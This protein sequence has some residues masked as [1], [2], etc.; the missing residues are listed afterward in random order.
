MTSASRKRQR[1]AKQQPVLPSTEVQPLTTE[2][3]SST[4]SQASHSS[5][6]PPIAFDGVGHSLHHRRQSLLYRLSPLYVPSSL[7][8]LSSQHSSL[9]DLLDRTL[10]SKSNNAALL[11]GYSGAGKSALM[12]SVLLDL[13]RRHSPHGRSFTSVRLNGRLHSDDTTG[14]R[15]LVRQL[16]VDLEMEAPPANA[17]FTG[18]YVYLQDILRSSVLASTPVFFLLDHFEAFAVDKSKQSLLYNLCDLLQG[19]YQLAI[20]GLSQRIDCYDLLEKRIKSRLAAHRLHF[21]PCREEGELVE[22]LSARLTLSREDIIKALEKRSRHDVDFIPGE[23]VE[24]IE[25]VEG[26]SAAVQLHNQAV[27]AV[28]R[29]KAVLELLRHHL[30]LGKSVRWFLTWVVSARQRQSLGAQPID[31][32]PFTTSSHL[33]HCLFCCGVLLMLC[34]LRAVDGCG[35]SNDLR[36]AVSYCGPLHVS[37]RYASPHCRDCSPSYPL[38]LSCGCCAVLCAVN[39]ERRSARQQ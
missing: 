9:F 27:N 11:I 35:V 32:R 10:T 19:D 4:V 1:E 12:Q 17:D 26:V 7:P 29:D 23:I 33:R 34:C 8:T 37:A 36:E 3:S 39:A 21:T 15:E 2:Q 25:E 38:T 24:G 31:D 13:H 6:P 14:M 16:T 28:F 5:P 30:N 18:L 22:I 20:I